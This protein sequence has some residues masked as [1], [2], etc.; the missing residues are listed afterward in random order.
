MIFE[1]EKGDVLKGLIRQLNSFFST[2]TIENDLIFSLSEKVFNRCEFNF[3]KNINKYYSKSGEAYFNPYHSGQYTVFLYFFSNTIFK[4]QKDC[5]Q[6]ANKIY[7]LNRIMNACDLFY[8]VA[9]PEIFML[10]HPLGSVIGRGK[11]GNYFAFSQNCTVGN[12]NNIFPVIGEHVKMSANSVILGNS[13]IGNNVILGAGACVKD[14]NIPENSLVFG[15]SPNL[16]IKKK[17]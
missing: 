4:E 6:L 17:N 2:S 7:Y 14:E 5:L 8:E 10:D 16:I 1:I 9:L 11:I 15:N 3:S 13:N 12:N